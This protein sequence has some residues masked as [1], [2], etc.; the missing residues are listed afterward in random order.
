M[1]TTNAGSQLI[2]LKGTSHRDG[3]PST[4]FRNSVSNCH[5][6]LGRN[7]HL[8]RHSHVD[9]YHLYTNF[10]HHL[11]SLARSG[12]GFNR[13]RYGDRNRGSCSDGTSAVQLERHTEAS[14]D[15]SVEAVV[16]FFRVR[17]FGNDIMMSTAK[18]SA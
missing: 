15:W 7:H 4:P 8:Q 6:E 2:I 5:N 3:H 16:N 17:G 18:E 13:A 1:A 12:L 14:G 9:S 11:G 10:R